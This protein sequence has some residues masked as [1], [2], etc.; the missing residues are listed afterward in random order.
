VVNLTQPLITVRHLTP[1]PNDSVRL[2]HGLLSLTKRN[3][4]TQQLLFF[5][6][7]YHVDGQLDSAHSAS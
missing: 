7:S 1:K 4:W 5:T 3:K 6:H 2:H